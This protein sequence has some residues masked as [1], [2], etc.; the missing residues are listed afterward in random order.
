[1]KREAVLNYSDSTGIETE[2]DGFIPDSLATGDYYC[3]VPWIDEKMRL[4][5]KNSGNSLA[6]SPALPWKP[7][8]SPGDTIEIYIRLQK[9]FVDPAK[10]TG[11][12]ICEHECPV[13]SIRAIRVTSDNESRNKT[14]ALII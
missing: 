13:R 5:I 14:A 4:I 11:C 2:K 1:V 7:P 9:P 8:P 6:V 3:R 12:G 10:C